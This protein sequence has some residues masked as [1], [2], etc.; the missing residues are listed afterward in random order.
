MNR[1]IVKLRSGAPVYFPKRMDGKMD[2]SSQLFDYQNQMEIA[3]SDDPWLRKHS[4]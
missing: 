3:T 1:D 2:R 4:N